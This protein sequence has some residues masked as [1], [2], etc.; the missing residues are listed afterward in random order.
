MQE[1]LSGPSLL[2]EYD[3]AALDRFLS[4]L[5]PP[6]A[7]V[8]LADSSF[9]GTTTHVEQWWVANCCIQHTNVAQLLAL[10]AVPAVQRRSHEALNRAR[11]F[12]DTAPGPGCDQVSFQLTAWSSCPAAAHH[13]YCTARARALARH[14]CC[15][16]SPPSPPPASLPRYGAR[17]SEESLP[18]ALYDDLPYSSASISTA[19]TTVPPAPTPPA[20]PAPAPA[21]VLAAAPLGPDSPLE[22]L[23]ARLALPFPPNW[24]LPLLDLTLLPPQQERGPEQQQQQQQ[25]QGQGEEHGMRDTREEE[26]VAG[27]AAARSSRGQVGSAGS[28]ARA[29]EQEAADQP[30]AQ[31]QAQPQGVVPVL[32]REGRG[33]RL[34]HARDTSFGVPKVGAGLWARVAQGCRD[35]SGMGT[36][37]QLGWGLWAQGLGALG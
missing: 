34:W 29:S 14:C 28:E 30:P 31:A 18:A 10:Q 17:Y 19:T 11:Q 27:S 5:Q 7:T 33:V 3:S 4:Y 35:V 26:R 20:P 15:S 25:Q 16:P 12:Y 37:I 9:A 36:R 8:Y 13:A 6:T 24:A 1:L 21:A 22:A 2:Y 23:A 32:L